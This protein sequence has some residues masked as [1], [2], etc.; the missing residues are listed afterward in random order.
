[1]VFRSMKLLLAVRNVVTWPVKVPF[2]ALQI[3]TSAK[4][5]LD[6]PFL[7]SRRLNRMG[8]HRFRV[9]VAMALC[10][11]RRGRLARH[12]PV[13]WREAFDRDGF[14]AIPDIVPPEQF[15]QLRAEILAWAGEAREMKQGEA[16]TRRLA[17]DPVMLQAIPLL[18]DL[19]TRPDL[20]ALF[21]YVA[22]FRVEPLHYVQTIVTGPES[23]ERDPQEALHADAFHSSLKAWLFLNHVDA[24]GAPFTY[25]PGS[26]RLGPERLEWEY[27]RSLA[28]PLQID[29]LSAR[30]SPRVEDGELEALGLPSP[31]PLIASANTLV[32]ADTFG[33]HARGA[34]RRSVERVEIWSYSRR[35]PFLPWLGGDILSLPGLAERR[36]NWLWATRDLL[37]RWV[38]QPWRPVG[39]RAP[40]DELLTVHLVET[41]SHQD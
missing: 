40:I 39:K 28:D 15:E 29:R 4:S 38:G 35:N 6:N 1:M 37:E 25:V 20:R 23:V 19:L 14:V 2:W 26:H 33:F 7:G 24:E 11:M 30:G 5:R 13:A 32:V 22:S 12:V 16:V 31:L 10:R 41:T 18:H 21:H 34:A 17:V 3:G 9:S 36:V 8:L 27:R